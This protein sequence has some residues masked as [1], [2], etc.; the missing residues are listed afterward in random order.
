MDEEWVKKE[1][2]IT[3]AS[4]AT[5]ILDSLILINPMVQF[6]PKTQ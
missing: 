2:Q 5:K 6:W 3:R 1:R 4:A